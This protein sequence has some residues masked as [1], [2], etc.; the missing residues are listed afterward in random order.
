[1]MESSR[2][3]TTTSRFLVFTSAGDNSNLKLWFQGERN[4]DVWINYYGDDVDKYKDTSNYYTQRKGGKFPNLHYIYQHYKDLLDQYEAILVM[5]DDIIINATAISQLFRVRDDLDLSILQPSFDAKGKVSH[6]ITL[7]NPSY[8]LRLTNFVEVTCPLFN[9]AI[10]D[11]FMDVYDPVLVGWGIDWWFLNLLQPD[12]KGK[13]A[14]VDA[15]SCI[16]PLDDSKG[17]IREIDQLQKLNERILNWTKIKQDHGLIEF[18]HKVFGY[19][20]IKKTEVS[21]WQAR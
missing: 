4:F 17:G 16:N 8:Y 2:I 10:L 19:I 15:I 6:P 20:N 14:I 21:K 3:K 18:K 5:D 9:K 1:M 11:E 13:V 12:I 7:Y